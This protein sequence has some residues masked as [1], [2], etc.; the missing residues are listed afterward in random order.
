MMLPLRIRKAEVALAD[1]RLEEA[2][3]QAIREDVRDHRKGQRLIGR[4][5]KAY[6]KRARVHLDAGNHAAALTDAE[7]ASRLGG[8]QPAIVALQDEIRGELNQHQAAV[9]ARHQKLAAAKRCMATGAYSMG[10]KLCEDVSDGHTVVGLMHDAELNRRIVEATL[11]R[12]RKALQ[13]KE[14]ER[15]L[16]AID[17]GVK[18]QPANPEV[19]ELVSKVT[20]AVAVQ[21]RQM[22]TK[23][24]LD[25]AD[26]YLHR[27]QRHAGESIEV[28]EL[29]RVLE[30][31]RRLSSSLRSVHVRETVADLKALKLIIPEARWLD[32]A[33]RDSE[34]I[35]NSL[36]SLQT[37][38][39]GSL[40]PDT[41]A[42]ATLYRAPQPKKSPERQSPMPAPA[43]IFHAT[44]VIP[45]N[46]VIHL[47]GTGSVLVSRRSFVTLGTPGR[48]RQLDIP[49]QGKI[50]QTS[51]SIERIDEDYFLTS[52]QP[53]T[54]N[55]KPTANTLLNHGDQI[56]IGR[57]GSMQFGLPNA[58][59]TSATIDFAGIRLATGN[60]RRVILMDDSLV[61]GPQSSAHIQSLSLDRSM[62]LHWRNGELR[63]RPL[64]RSVEN[65]GVLLQMNQP[66]EIDGLSLVVTEAKGLV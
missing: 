9:Q 32:G 64:N 37:G 63:M 14:W 6:E 29:S 21:V 27:L 18:Q 51:I 15:A 36:E 57:R 47:D 10:A 65:E 31:C 39:I 62:V 28:R 44:P 33:I 46:F 11:E 35:A 61:I 3:Q 7:R 48:S 49:I 12:G 58:A 24:R 60:T 23:G 43:R 54:V 20:A 40:L 19:A 66:Q 50:G 38:P 42:E 53:L 8:N 17:E 41:A 13:S 52:E 5:T 22:I 4:L 25:Q 59:S 26:L 16:D 56:R 45:E 30:Q 55:G 2:W 1:G 34:N